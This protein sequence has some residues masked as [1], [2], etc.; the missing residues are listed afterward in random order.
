MTARGRTLLGERFSELHQGIARFPLGCAPSTIRVGRS[1]TRIASDAGDTSSTCFR[2]AFS[3]PYR[4]RK[5]RL[6]P[7]SLCRVIPG[8]TRPFLPP[9]IFEGGC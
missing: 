1:D 5:E 3:E 8:F 4:G 6:P 7:W 9:R 2:S